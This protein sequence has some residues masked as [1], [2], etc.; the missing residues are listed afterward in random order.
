MNSICGS[1]SNLVLDLFSKELPRTLKSSI[2]PVC[3]AGCRMIFDIS[4]SGRILQ[5]RPH[6]T[7]P[8]NHG[9]A[10]VQ[11]RFLLRK[12]LQYS[13]RPVA[14][15]VKENGQFT[16]VSWDAAL[17]IAATRLGGFSPGQVA[18]LADGRTTNEE[19]YVLQKFAKTALKSEFLGCFAPSGHADV[20]EALKTKIGLAGASGSLDNLQN[21]GVIFALGMHGAGDHP[22]AGTRIRKAVM[23]GAKL[24]TASAVHNAITRY[25]DIHLDT[26]PGTELA[27]LAGLLR[28][29]LMNQQASAPLD[30]DLIALAGL[31]EPF[32]L[33]E[34]A[35][36]TGASKEK[37]I[38]ASCLLTDRG[39]LSVAFG[40]AVLNSSSGASIV[41]ALLTVVSVQGSFGGI[42]PLYGNG[43]LQGARDMGMLPHTLTVHSKDATI[44]KAGISDWPASE[45]VRGLCL[46]AESHDSAAWATLEPHLSKMEFVL[47]QDIALPEAI[48]GVLPN[49]TV[50]LPMAS[51]LEKE[52][53]LTNCEH[54]IQRVEPVVCPAGES[55]SSLW[56]I[57]ELARRMGLTGFEFENVEAVFDLIR[58]E[59]PGYSDG[60]GIKAFQPPTRFDR[61]LTW[62]PSVSDFQV[63]SRDKEQP[64]G[65]IPRER[66][67]PYMAGPLSS[68]ESLSVIGNGISIEMNPADAFG[69][70]FQPGDIVSV[71]TRNGALEGPL[72]MSDLLPVGT[73][74][75]PSHMLG[76][77]QEQTGMNQTI[78][79]ARVEKR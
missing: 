61:S 53:T 21:S 6:P 11:G 39:P 60:C 57:S 59:V 17:D 66:L 18:V 26:Y 50:F 10:C 75:I 31:L 15:L 69:M 14:P 3:S 35:R 70:G 47:I 77:L 67:T 24:I 33:D 42:F 55:K 16:E 2:C 78:F 46:I 23:D 8:A 25:A 68:L 52:G 71:T 65:L 74:A 1:L 62:V 9:Q 30:Q 40:K 29:I 79:A 64:F 44:A 28:L 73:V 58:K 48:K 12:R 5:S 19:L 32:T 51:I 27:L 34:V 76:D 43:N 36:I 56:M 63:E 72:A 13:E 49:G 54:R 4:Q 22:I 45:N 38:E 20:A 37:I 41:D 7:G